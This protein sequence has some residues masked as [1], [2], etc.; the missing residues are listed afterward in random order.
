[1][2]AH[3]E[4]A[5]EGKWACWLWGGAVLSVSFKVRKT[6][7]FRALVIG[8]ICYM[9]VSYPNSAVENNDYNSSD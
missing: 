7:M 8:P 5:L 9:A 3:R 4:Q 1:M 6:A 2:K